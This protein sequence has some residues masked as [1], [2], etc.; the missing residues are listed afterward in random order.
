MSCDSSGILSLVQHNTSLLSPNRYKL[1]HTAAEIGMAPLKRYFSNGLLR[2][3]REIAV[4][5]VNHVDI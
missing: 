4:F 2:G 3:S 1:R 5:T